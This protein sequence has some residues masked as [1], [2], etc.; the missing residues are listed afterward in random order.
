MT[1]LRFQTHR[2]DPNGQKTAAEPV[3]SIAGLCVDRGKRRIVEDVGFTAQ[4]GTLLGLVGPNGAGKST[5]VCAIAGLLPVRSGG[6]RIAGAETKRMP[7]KRL[8]R[9]V[10][11]LP[12][13]HSV[14]W[15][16]RVRHLV[17]LGRLPHLGPFDVMKPADA[18]A[19]DAALDRAGAKRFAD[20]AVD[21]L[22]GGEQ[23]AVMLARALAVDAPILLADEPVNSLD[24]Y[25]QL[26]VMELLRGIAAEGRLVIA[27]LH[28]LALA[29][30][31]CDRLLLLEAG[32]LVADGPPQ[33]CLAGPHLRRTYGVEEHYGEHDRERYVLP[34]RRL[35]VRP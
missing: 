10:A 33:D 21:T 32:R 23:T 6:V 18:A 16:L 24:P 28:D 7:R 5:L 26:Q 34:W 31:F 12:Q 22:S 25:H 4:A 11:Y 3:L 2:A 20:R 35:A 29:A 30:R 17:A 1:L 27:V 8:A 9:Q 19:V 14:D 13:G 15:S